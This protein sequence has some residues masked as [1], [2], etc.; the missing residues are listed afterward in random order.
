[1]SYQNHD[2]TQPDI[3]KDLALADMLLKSKHMSPFEHQ[4]HSAPGLRDFWRNFVGWAQHRA[5]LE[6]VI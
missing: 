1:M 6:E 3:E 2:Q 4:A 5:Y